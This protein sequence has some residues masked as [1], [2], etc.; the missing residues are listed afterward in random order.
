[1][2]EDPKNNPAR[3]VAVPQQDQGG[4]SVRGRLC[5][6]RGNLESLRER[7]I[8]AKEEWEHS[9]PYRMP[10]GD[11][12]KLGWTDGVRVAPN[13]E[14]QMNYGLTIIPPWKDGGTL[15]ANFPEHFEH[16]EVGHGILRYSDKRDNPWRIASDG[17]SA[18]YEVESPELPGVIVHASAVARDDWVLLTLAEATGFILFSEMSLPEALQE[19]TKSLSVRKGI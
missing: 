12:A 19:L 2:G 8:K 9:V 3:G 14:D 15:H 17:N 5:L 10:I 1:M 7:W 13:A 4:A 18:T 16:G 11:S 6:F